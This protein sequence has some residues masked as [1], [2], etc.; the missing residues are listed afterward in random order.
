MRRMTKLIP[1]FELANMW[2]RYFTGAVQ[3]QQDV[4]KM[5]CVM[6]FTERELAIAPL[7]K[8]APGLVYCSQDAVKTQGTMRQIDQPRKPLIQVKPTPLPTAF[9]EGER[10]SP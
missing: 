8:T 1:Y 3:Y 5:A 7:Y 9:V 6:R 4:G 10:V 2:V